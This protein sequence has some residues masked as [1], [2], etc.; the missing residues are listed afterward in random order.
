VPRCG[1]RAVT[2]HRREAALA[3]RRARSA[4]LTND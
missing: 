4:E 2:A 1:A 3:A